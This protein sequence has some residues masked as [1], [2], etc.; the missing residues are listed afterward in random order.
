MGGGGARRPMG[1]GG[2]AAPQRTK[3]GGSGGGRRAAQ[4][5]RAGAGEWR[6][7]ELRASGWAA[8]GFLLA[9]ARAELREVVGSACPAWAGVSA[10]P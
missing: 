6:R 7:A 2:S 9:G 3:G 4:C 5:G 1:R 8:P 10:R